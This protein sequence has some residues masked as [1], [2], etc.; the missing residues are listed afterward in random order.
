MSKFIDLTGERFGRLLVV[1]FSHISKGGKAYWNTI[2]DCNTEKTVGSYHLRS[3]ATKSCGCLSIE[4]NLARGR[5]DLTGRRFGRLLVVERTNKRS[6]GSAVYLCKC[7]CGNF[8][9]VRSGQ[10][11]SGRHTKSCGCL[12]RDTVREICMAR[13][14]ELHPNWDPELT[15]EDRNAT[16]LYPEYREWRA[17][18]YKRDRYT[19]QKCGDGIGAK[20]A[21]HHIDG[22]KENEELRTELSNGV[23]LCSECHNKFHSIYG[24]GHNTSQQFAEFMENDWSD[25]I[26]I[27]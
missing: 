26:S 15:D 3:G 19:C 23:T 27:K 10:L 12:Q 11:A 25:N 5:G 24:R 9:E 7:D 16:R 8:T 20:L 14:G 13:I 21:A 1:S 6:Y 17:S 2:C 18:V 4:L 22:Y